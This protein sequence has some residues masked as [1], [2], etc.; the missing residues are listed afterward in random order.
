MIDWLAIH[1]DALV[2][3][4]VLLMAAMTVIIAS[5]I[6]AAVFLGVR[7]RRHTVERQSELFTQ[8]VATL[9]EGLALNGRKRPNCILLDYS[10]PGRNG[11]GVLADILEN[12]PAANVIMLTGQGSETVAVE[13]SALAVSCILLSGLKPSASVVLAVSAKISLS[14]PPPGTR[15]STLS[16]EVAI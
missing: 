7:M 5:T 6:G 14:C 8:A 16:G 4:A 15:L 12:D 11:L 13:V 1:K 2:A 10:L 3:L 9:E